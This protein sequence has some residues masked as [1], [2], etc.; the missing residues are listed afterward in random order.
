MST[1]KFFE[2]SSSNGVSAQ[3]IPNSKKKSNLPPIPTVNDLLLIGRDELSRMND[4]KM[5]LKLLSRGNSKQTQRFS[6][7]PPSAPN[8]TEEE[9]NDNAH[10]SNLDQVFLRFSLLGNEDNDDYDEAAEEEEIIETEEEEDN[11]QVDILSQYLTDHRFSLY[12]LFELGNGYSNPISDDSDVPQSDGEDTR[13][14]SLPFSREPED[15][16]LHID[17]ALSFVSDIYCGNSFGSSRSHSTNDDNLSTSRS[18]TT[19]SQNSGRQEVRQNSSQ[20]PSGN[21]S[22]IN[23][24]RN[25]GPPS[26]RNRR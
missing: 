4:L 20:A 25:T 9:L 3:I 1:P 14:R 26:A 16:S 7:P 13:S 24:S 10:P 15:L 22:T 18:S 23:S 11:D 8:Y 12:D 5:Q 21:P 2:M 6:G 17:D 19:R